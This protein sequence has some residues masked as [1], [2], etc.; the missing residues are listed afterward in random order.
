MDEMGGLGESVGRVCVV[1]LSHYWKSGRN[2]ENKG[3][4]SHD[5]N[6]RIRQ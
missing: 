5:P 2:S 6:K 1:C 3:H 4:E